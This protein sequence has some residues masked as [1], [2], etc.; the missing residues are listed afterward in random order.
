MTLSGPTASKIKA[1][2]ISFMASLRIN[3][4]DLSVPLQ[5]STTTVN[6]AQFAAG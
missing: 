5:F 3:P 6:R 4:S 2:R 1:A